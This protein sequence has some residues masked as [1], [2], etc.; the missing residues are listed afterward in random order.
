MYCRERRKLIAAIE[1]SVELYR[2]VVDSVVSLDSAAP[3]AAM[4]QANAAYNACQV[5]RT[6]L[7]RHERSHGCSVAIGPLAR[8]A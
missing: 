5:C 2:T 7:R 8:T 4:E 3:N 6:A 1:D